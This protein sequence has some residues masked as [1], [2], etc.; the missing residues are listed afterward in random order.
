M[1]KQSIQFWFVFD[2]ILFAIACPIIYTLLKNKIIGIITI[3]I[4]YVLF[5]VNIRLPGKIFYRSDAILYYLVGAYIGI[6]FFKE[7]ATRLVGKWRVFSMLVVFICLLFIDGDMTAYKNIDIQP[8]LLCVFALAAWGGFD[9]LK[10]ETYYKFEVESFLI[11]AMHLNVGAIVTKILYLFLPKN[12]V[13]SVV[14][15]LGT[16]VITIL[17][18]VNFSNIIGK[19]SPKLKKLVS[20]SR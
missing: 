6:H 17:L 20:G 8:I 13:F 12:T 5:C 11:Y 7:F 14:N 2:L 15:Y 16:I 19:V 1:Y 10:N 9:L 3:L 4:S 18:I